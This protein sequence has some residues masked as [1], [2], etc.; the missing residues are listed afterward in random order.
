MIILLYILK[1]TIKLLHI[2]MR[3]QEQIWYDDFIEILHKKYPQKTQLI[4]SLKKILGLKQVAIYRRMQK[5][6]FFSVHEISKI[7]TELNISLDEITRIDSERVAFHLKQINYLNPSNEEVIFLRNI[8]QS[9]YLFRN[10]PDTEF[11]DISNRLPRQLIAGYEH[12]NRFFLFKW[13]YQY[14]YDCDFSR[15]SEISVSD[16]K[17]RVTKEYYQAIKQVPQTIFVWDR[18]IFHY[19][20]NDIRYFIS[21]YLITDEEKELLKKDL[22]NLLDYMLEVADKGCYPETQNKVNLYISQTNIDTNYN[23]TFTP[24]ANICFVHAFEKFEIY[25]FHSEIVTNFMSWMQLYKKTATPI[26]QID[27]K[28]RIEFFMQQKQLVNNL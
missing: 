14:G 8:I 24:E 3:T 27:E 18:L 1:K 17:L 22:N 16:E 13:R 10:Y 21:I 9:I 26:S 7:A 15:F 25:T 20:V 28:K 5:Q 23:Y 19:L 12:L 2:I 4:K 11:M 6:V